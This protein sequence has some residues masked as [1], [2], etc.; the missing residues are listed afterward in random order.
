MDIQNQIDL[1]VLYAKNQTL[2][3]IKS[4]FRISDVTEHCLQH[5]VSLD[6]AL[7]LMAQMVLHK[8]APMSVLVGILHHHFGDDAEVQDLQACA[9]MIWKAAEVDIIDFD[10]LAWQ[11]VL[12]HDVAAKVYEDLE[13]YQ[14]PLPMVI[15][16]LEVTNNHSTGYV[17]IRG[18]MILRDNHHEDDI[19]L[20][21]IN[22]ANQVALVINAD[23]ARMIQ[24]Q[25]KNLDKIK[26][27]ESKR[28]FDQRVRAFEKYDLVSRDVMESLYMTGEPFW[29][30]H[31][32]D[33]RGRCY[34]QG[35]HVSTQSNSWGK[36]V[37]EFAKQ[38]LVQ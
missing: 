32:Y 14:Y 17:T 13:R 8:R 36:A 19:C 38:E 1:E 16:P 21:H 10:Q 4:E 15:P 37:I 23:T 12:R 20:D 33:K 7:D 35:Y 3:R 9:D 24:N 31:K 2:T 6:F 28:D 5:E 30:T 26:P 11:F 22:R 18:S 27:R 25:W 29:L 34:A